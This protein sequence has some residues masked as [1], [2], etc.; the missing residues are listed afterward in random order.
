MTRAK[1]A[2]VAEQTHVHEDVVLDRTIELS[3]ARETTDITTGLTTGPKIG[4]RAPLGEISPNSLTN[5]SHEHIQAERRTPSKDDKSCQHESNGCQCQG[6]PHA[7]GGSVSEQ[8]H[9]VLPD[10]ND[11]APSPASQAA[12]HDLLKEVPDCK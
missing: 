11:S 2:E 3:E 9:E 6:D 10:Q 4:Q 12:A 8:L 7:A 5:D 1:A